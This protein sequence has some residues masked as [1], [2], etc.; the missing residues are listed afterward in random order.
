MTNRL[1][2]ILTA[3]GS[4][5]ISGSISLTSMSA[6][7]AQEIAISVSPMVTMSQLKGSQARASFSVTNKGTIPL[8]TRIYAQDFDYDREKG[9]V[10]AATHPNSASPFLQFSPRE[11]VIP[12][13]VT[14]DV[15]ISITIPP[16]KPDGEYRVAVFTED[17]TERKITDPNQKFVTT[18][19]PQIASVFF[20]AKGNISSQL[21]A[22]SV[23]WNENTKLPR[24]VLKNQG[25]ASAYPTVNWKLEQ[26]G[27]SVVNSEIQGVILQSG[28]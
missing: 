3:I 22:V 17:L 14:R 16:S 8:R 26:S 27:K 12:P 20:V 25:Q 11:L 19:R 18:I 1:L 24:L 4:A 21:S 7:R 9:Y 28:K 10:K 13:G 15:R 6:V 5:T 23:S 2:S